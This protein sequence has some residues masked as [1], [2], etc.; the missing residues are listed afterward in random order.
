M[1][2]DRTNWKRLS[3]IGLVLVIV[4][5]ISQIL[6]YCQTQYQLVSPIIPQNIID[7]LTKPYLTLA[8]ICFVFLAV[9]SICHY[10]HKYKVAL[11]LSSIAILFPYLYIE[12][13]G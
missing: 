11:I 6:G 7:K 10:F 1:T 12:L 8:G 2:T 5:T 13:S 3:I 9:V 4:T